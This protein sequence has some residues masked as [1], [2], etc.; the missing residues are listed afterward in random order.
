[1]RL[2]ASFLVRFLQGLIIGIGGI[3]PGISGG[4]MAVIFGVYERFTAF[5]AHPWQRW[6]QDFT[7]F[8]PY[9]IGGALGILLFAKA[10]VWCFD[11][12]PTPTICFF[13]GCILGT[14]PALFRT[15]TR[16][17]KVKPLYIVIAVLAFVLL[18][19][20][21]TFIASLGNGAVGDNITVLFIISG[22][23]LAL[24]TL[25]PGLSAAALMIYLG[26]Y[27]MFM[28]YLA[29]FQVLPMIPMGVGFLLTLLLLARLI[30]HLFCHYH[31]QVYFAIMGIV[32][33]SI[34]AIWPSDWANW[35][36]LLLA[37]AGFILAWRLSQLEPDSDAY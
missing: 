6:R 21:N 10:V 25:L 27:D 37:I 30:D 9:A 17:H 20:L 4:I 35:F 3:L 11:N 24:G 33:A 15:A 16:D 8:L 19:L 31:G 23:L 26:T 29:T 22:A 12:Y 14:G 7:F 5:L 18:M 28:N 13:I 1:M 34:I 32:L 36:N 2:S